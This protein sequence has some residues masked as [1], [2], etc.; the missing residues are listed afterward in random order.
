MTGVGDRSPR[1]V[2]RLGRKGSGALSVEGMTASM[3]TRPVRAGRRP[4]ARRWAA[5]LWAAYA[6]AVAFAAGAVA[7]FLAADVAAHFAAGPGTRLWPLGAF[8]IGFTAAVGT[9]PRTG[10]LGRARAVGASG[11]GV[12]ALLALAV[13][14]AP[15][16]AFAVAAA[17]LLGAASGTVVAVSGRV[18]AAA[19]VGDG[20]ASVALSAASLLAGIAAGVLALLALPLYGW[21]GVFGLLVVAAVLAAWK[22]AEH[23]PKDT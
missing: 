18:L 22:F 16:F 15:G 4:A 20:S 17:G 14:L 19:E 7:A 1:P 8:A 13:A 21:R 11:A 9:V 10:P 12:L 23:V 3:E 6:Q 2:V 5:A